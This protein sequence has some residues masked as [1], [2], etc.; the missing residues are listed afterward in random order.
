VRRDGVALG[1]VGLSFV[2]LT[3]SALLLRS[4]AALRNADI[5]FDE[6]GVLT[7]VAPARG[8][9]GERQV[10]MQ[11]M[12][13]Q[14]AALPGV[15]AVTAASP[16][17][18]DGLTQNVRW[19]TEEMAAD[20]TRF[21]QTNIHLVLPG[22]FEAVRGRLLAGRTFTEADNR[23]DVLNVVIDSV[24]AA[25]AFGNEPAVGRRLLLRV[26]TNEPEMFQ[27]IGV[28]AH[29]RHL[30]LAGE[31][32]EAVFLPYGFLDHGVANRWAVRTTGDPLALAESV[33][34]VVRDID[35]L[36]AVA[37]IQPFSALRDR[38]AAPTRF[39]LVLIGIFAA[40]AV[41]LAAIGLYGVL[42]T[43]VR[44]R[45]AEIG[46]RVAF[47]ASRPRILRLIIGQG[48]ALSL[49]GLAAGIVGAAWLTTLAA[50]MFTPVEPHHP[51]TFAATGALFLLI[52]LA[53]CAIPA[54]RAARMDPATA[55][56]ED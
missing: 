48:L 25:K 35:P 19:G 45:T 5:G 16:L 23:P 4:F 21:Q 52:A 13:Q 40:I 9:D 27:V 8:N 56:R 38:A 10:F 14:L 29:Q 28:V 49:A 22:Y 37:E 51:P 50:G 46:V 33:R 18:L 36:T 34:N 43:A 42:S 26:R 44:Q 6:T 54:L 15:Q 39:A 11:Q 55:L 20:P 24:L 3:G 1:E 53:A 30:A 12:Q 47:G 31:P 7:F 32:K 17:P 41:F 2:L